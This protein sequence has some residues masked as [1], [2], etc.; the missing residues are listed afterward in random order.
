MT[1][2]DTLNWEGNISK[3]CAKASTR[4]H[5]LKLLKRAGMPT[6][7]LLT[8]YKTVIRPVME[9]GSIVWQ[10]NITEDQAHRLG[11]IQRRAE[12]IIYCNNVQTEQLTPVKTRFDLH[13]KHFFN[14]LLLPTNCLHDLLPAARHR[15]VTEKLRTVSTLP[16]LFARTERYKRSFLLYNMLQV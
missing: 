13:A 7:E 6:N 10:A 4:L 1:V 3:I 2:T 15:E 14:S 11:A 5:F 12:R 9:Y 16:C 8:Y